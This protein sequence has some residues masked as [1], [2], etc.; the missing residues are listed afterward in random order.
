MQTGNKL[1]ENAGNKAPEKSG[2]QKETG[3]KDQKDKGLI[4]EAEDTDIVNGQSQN[5]VTNAGDELTG[6]PEATDDRELTEE[7]RDQ[8]LNNA[9]DALNNDNYPLPPDERHDTELN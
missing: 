8:E 7:E 4:T 5:Q 1:T 2:P 9:R 3:P 6:A